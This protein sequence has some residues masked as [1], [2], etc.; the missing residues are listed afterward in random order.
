MGQQWD[1]GKSQQIL[2]NKWKWEHNNPKSLGHWESNPNRE[3]HS[4]TGLLKKKKA[5]IYNLTSHL[6][7][8]EKGQ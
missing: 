1:Q 5:Q 6:K 2:W 7:E 8:F 4:I 3:I